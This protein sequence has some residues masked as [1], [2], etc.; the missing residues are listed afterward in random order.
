MPTRPRD[1]ARG[2]E[3]AAFGAERTGVVYRFLTAVCLLVSF[4]GQAA[5][6]GME[7][8]RI[9]RDGDGYGVGPNL[10]GSDADDNDKTVHTPA[11][12]LAKYG[13]LQALL[14]H[15]GYNPSRLFFLA[16]DG[17]NAT[18]APND[19]S[20]PYATWTYLKT[21]APLR[22]GDAVLFRGG[23]Y[24][25]TIAL[26]DFYGQEGN[27]LIVMAYPGEQVTLETSS[28]NNVYLQHTSNAVLDGFNLVRSGGGGVGIYLEGPPGP[29][30]AP[31]PGCYHLAIRNIYSTD[32]GREI[33]GMQDLQDLL[34][35]NCVLTHSASHIVYL[36]NREQMNANGSIT[37]RNNVLYGDRPYSGGGWD[38]RPAFQH[39]GKVV[40]CVVEGNIFHS[41]GSDA[42]QVMRGFRNSIIRNNLIFNNDNKGICFYNYDS[43]YDLD[44]NMDNLVE[45]NII[46]VGRY[47]ASAEP[48]ADTP[49]DFPAIFFSDLTGVGTQMA[50]NVI[51]NNILMTYN[52]PPLRFSHERFLTAN[53]FENNTLFRVNGP[54][55][56]ALLPGSYLSFDVFKTYTPRING[57]VF[58]NPGFANVSVDYYAT[59]ERFDFSRPGAGGNHA[60]LLD[61]I[62]D[63]NVPADA[64]LAFT[65]HA[66]DPDGDPITY[67]ALN[68]PGG[69]IL[70]GADFSWTPTAVQAGVYP[71]AFVASDGRLQDLRT[72]SITVTA[73]DLTPPTVVAVATNDTNH[74]RVVFSEP[75]SQASAEAPANYHSNS[76]VTLSAPALGADQKT[77]TLATST[78]VKGTTYSLTVSGVADP[79]GNVMAAATLTYQYDDGLAAHYRLD[80]TS[81]AAAADTS[82][83][84]PAG[85]LQNGAAWCVG[86]ING[87]VQLDGIDDYVDCGNAAPDAASALTVAVWVK[88]ANP[89]Q[90][91]YMRVL[92]KKQLWNDPSGFELEYQPLNNWLSVSGSGSDYARAENVDLD[93]NWHHVAAVINQNTAALYVDG[94]ERT[95]DSSITPLAANSLGLALGRRG[96]GGDYFAGCL[97]D[98]RLYSRAFSPAEVL[99]LYREAPAGAPNQ[100]PSANAGPDQIVTDANRN[101][102]ESVTLNGTASRDPDGTIA[103][104]VWK[105]GATQIAT[106]ANPTVTLPVGLHLITLTVADNGG[107]TSTDSVFITIKSPPVAGAGDDRVVVDT[108]WNG[109]EPVALDASASS[110]VDGTI[111]SYVWREGALQLA[112]GVKPTVTLAVGTHT[113]TLTVTD[114]DGLT[115]ADTAVIIV[116]RAIQHT[117]SAAAGAGGAISPTG[118]VT[119]YEG[120]GQ[121][122]II[123]PQTGYRIADVVVDGASRGAV[124]S[125][126]FTNVAAD[127][128]VSAVFAPAQYVINATGNTGGS[129]TPNG[130]V[131]V[132]AGGSQTFTF[133]PA[134][135]Y[136]IAEVLVDGVSQGAVASYA[137]TNVTASHTVQAAFA[138]LDSHTIAATAQAGGS[139]APAGS[140]SVAS[141]GTQQFTITPNPGYQIADVLVDGASRGALATYAFTNVSADHSISALFA[142]A[143]HTITAT[144]ETGGALQPTGAVAVA[145]GANQTFTIAAAAGCRLAEV[146]VDG[147]SQG[148]VNSYT[149]NNVTADHAILARF[150]AQTYTIRTSLSGRGRL[151]PGGAVTVNA[152]QDQTF[153]I[154]PDPQWRVAEVLIDGATQGVLSSYTFRSVAA[155]HALQVRFAPESPVLADRTPPKVVNVSPRPDAVQT[156]LN[157][158]VVLHVIDTGAGVD[159]NTVLVRVDDQTVYQGG[160]AECASPAGAC[161]RTGGNS[162]YAFTFQPARS[163]AFE[164]RV[165]VSVS[166]GDLAGNTMPQPHSSSFTTEMR[167]FGGLMPVAAPAAAPQGNGQL[168]CDNGGNLWAVWHAGASGARD[169]YAARLAPGAAAFGVPV[170]LTDNPADQCN[171]T[172]AIDAGGA[173]CVAWQDNRT[174]AWD[175]RLR[176][177]ADGATWSPERDFRVADRQNFSQTRPKL[178]ASPDT[179]GWFYLAWQDTRAA[180]QDIYLA[181]TTN[182]FATANV[183]AL[184]TDTTSQTEPAVA[185]AGGGVVYVVWTDQRNRNFD[186]YGASSANGWANV[187]VVRNSYRQTSPALAVELQTGRLHL[188]W[189]DDTPGQ[190]DV[191]YAASDNGL[192]TSPVTGVSI[193]DDSAGAAQ[194]A[195]T[196]LVGRE[197]PQ[198]RIFLCWQ[199]SRNVALGG[200]DLDI[201]FA[202]RTQIMGTNVLVTTQ[203]GGLSQYGPALA[204]GAN[205]Q[206]CLLWMQDEAGTT[207]L[208]YAGTTAVRGEP[209]AANLI[210]AEQGG[211]VGADPAHIA[212]LDDVSVELPPGAFWVDVQVS[213][214]PIDNPVPATVTSP[215]DIIARYEIGPSSALEFAK[216]VT[217]TIPYNPNDVPDQSAFWYN[218]QTGELSQSGLSNI[219]HLVISPTLH[220]IR[221]ST[222][223]FTQYVLAAPA[224][225]QAAPLDSGG[226]GGG[227]CL[228]ACAVAP[229]TLAGFFLPYLA[230]APVLLALRRYDQRTRGG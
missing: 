10:L 176:T 155:D 28:D 39:N 78:H 158:L 200:N 215:L 52:G 121:T 211:R 97:D 55:R 74:I 36:G 138:P 59:P 175:V 19:S 50:N 122:F 190:P 146:L 174:G 101:G 140:V 206:P 141:G 220:A 14:A 124:P 150:A 3:K 2:G 203:P 106:G 133:S 66:T 217:I 182:G 56:T 135:G 115:G 58:Q 177:S 102:S 85:V 71:V 83:R 167:S 226:G 168:A 189:V 15:K 126:S 147:V 100:P 87:A 112:T 105:D 80:E 64:R 5:R 65:I 214:T 178:A 216:P 219:E 116:A 136:R 170:Q 132:S 11:T 123:S 201:Y 152:G 202:E 92:S 227:C 26:N 69:A 60:P 225:S 33:L 79:A 161:R 110:D 104:Y 166:A 109:S 180:N 224:Q 187:P 173:L 185:C 111:S 90:N 134:A 144:A 73:P 99:A 54:D 75:V 154:D 61:P 23:T 230:L 165:T 29:P 199:D 98:V 160:A 30:Y 196:I 7:V 210:H 53:T 8:L 12:W 228:S 95:T 46:W 183:R 209:L 142:A 197:T 22:A 1:V 37:F 117:I 27:P 207:R 49:A 84:S 43:G 57:N 44:D 20:K 35:E 24:N 159:P 120:A 25:E 181:E 82:G 21:N 68:L 212:G 9:D 229:A 113:L 193:I 145:H 34:I 130:A 195:P 88:I 208:Y 186:V 103:S 143:T 128:T 137:F 129:V 63:R 221:F 47:A 213:I 172:L 151:T 70:A 4:A 162:D 222:T 118:S 153:A 16:T 77:V 131:Q 218:P 191:F 93:A 125:Y 45:N 40:N 51:R 6:G 149:F 18:G 38:V 194:A 41:V 156:P 164:Q 157:A 81:G 184:T 96:G 223:H 169:I 48:G 198:P 94:V 179:P 188:A 31:M 204:L 89:G 76:G 108:D 17:N 171:P 119:V 127:H 192:P 32:H 86:R 107:A 62:G 139:I 205:G 42:I 148:A 13:N 67:S 163:F 91:A 114:D 72:I